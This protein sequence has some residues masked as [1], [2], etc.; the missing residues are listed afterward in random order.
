MKKTAFLA[1]LAAFTAP[2]S[3]QSYHYVNGY[4]TTNGTYVAPHYQT[5]PDSTIQNNWSTYPNVN[6]F[7]GQQGTINPYSYQAPRPVTTIPNY[8]SS[9]GNQSPLCGYPGS[10]PC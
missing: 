3:A 4:V 2:A 7:T 1:I 5:N 10:R 8:G 9:Y 6:P